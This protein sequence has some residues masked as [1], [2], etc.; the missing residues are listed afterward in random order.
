MTGW[1]WLAANI[2]VA[3]AINAAYI[4]TDAALW[5]R[6]Y[7]RQDQKLAADHERRLQAIR[8]GKP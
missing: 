2:G 8:S 6:H 1:D 7:R 5:R 3:A 4:L